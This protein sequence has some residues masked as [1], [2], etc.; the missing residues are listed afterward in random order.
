ME[1]TRNT[2]NWKKIVIAILAAIL[3][4]VT[5]LAVASNA[6][7]AGNLKTVA[8]ISAEAKTKNEY[9][10]PYFN[11]HGS[12]VQIIP[13]HVWYQ[14]GKMYADCYVVNMEP[15]TVKNIYV[16]ELALGNSNGQ[17]IADASFGKINGM[18][19]APRDYAS[20]RFVFQNGSFKNNVNL[21]NGI[22]Y[23]ARTSWTN[24]R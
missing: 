12:S 14:D 3:L 20:H 23:N 4:A 5:P 17:V 7:N 10:N 1:T 13:Y 9:Y 21:R 2:K 18:T 19:L 11:A 15:N 24:V 6:K 8:G 22:Q 16:N